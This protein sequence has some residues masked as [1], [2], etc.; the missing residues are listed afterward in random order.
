MTFVPNIFVFPFLEVC[1]MVYKQQNILFSC[2]S[3][4]PS[5]YTLSIVF[6][7]L[8]LAA[9]AI[10]YYSNYLVHTSYSCVCTHTSLCIIP[11]YY[12][13][14]TYRFFV[15]KMHCNATRPRGDISSIMQIP[16]LL[17]DFFICIRLS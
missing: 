12:K 9:F 10:I 8:I 1:S 15:M 11:R 6:S 3:F 5:L 2:R 17:A 16:P 4:L 13:R 14:S 7:N